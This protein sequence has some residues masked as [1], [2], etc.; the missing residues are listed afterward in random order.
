MQR[1]MNISPLMQK[2]YDVQQRGLDRDAI[3]MHRFG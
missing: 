3:R 1:L 2:V